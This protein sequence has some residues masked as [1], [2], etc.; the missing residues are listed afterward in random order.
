M[1]QLVFWT[2]VIALAVLTFK[3]GQYKERVLRFEHLKKVRQ[4]RVIVREVCGL[5]K[6]CFVDFKV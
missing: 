5:K 3:L 4:T 2:S 6:G 1:W